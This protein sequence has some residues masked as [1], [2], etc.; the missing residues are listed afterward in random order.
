MS[1]I[2]FLAPDNTLLE[3]AQEA[4]KAHHSDIPVVKGLLSEGVI[5]ASS[6]SDTGTEII[7][8]RGGTASAIRNAGIPVAVVEIPIT[9]FDIVRCVEKAKR[10]GN[11]IGVVSFSS[12]ILGIECLNSI[13]GVDIGLYPI[14]EEAEA[15]PQLIKALKDG[16]QVVIG[17]YITGKI[18]QK[19]NCPFELIE[20]G[21]EGLIQ[22]AEEAKRIAYARAL[23]KE[24]SGLFRAVL[25]YAYEGIISVDSQ[26]CITFFNPIAQRITNINSTEA[27]GRKI[28]EVWPNMDLAKVL[29][30]GEDDL[31]QI[32]TTNNV[33]VLCNKVPIR[34][35]NNIVGAVITFQDVTH[36]QKMEAKVRSSMY[37]CGHVANLCYSDIIGTS[38][39]I[40]QTIAIAK[41]YSLTNSSI[42]VIGETGSGKEVF[43]Q[44]IHNYSRRKHGPFVA[45][46]CAALPTN[47]L[48]SE[49]FGYVGGAFTGANQKG[50]PGLLE[51]AHGGT[52]F[53]D[54]I[55]EM[56]YITQGKLLRVLQ[57]KKVMRLGSDRVIPVDIRVIAATNK[58]LKILVN[59]NKFRA[60][61]YY[62]LNV[63]QLKIPPL[64]NRKEDI[65]LLAQLFLKMHADSF[66]R[67]LK[68]S[69]SAIEA[70]TQY[71]WPGNIRELKNI[72]ERIA[73]VHKQDVVD[74]S[75]IN[76]L[77]EDVS[78]SDKVSASHKPNEIEEINKA[79]ALAKG[80]YVDA[81]R[82]L[83]IDRSTL[84]RKMKRL[85]LK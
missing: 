36:I 5:I 70:L 57:E 40:I 82:I 21:V 83:G 61:L 32:I 85:K 2:T 14:Q 17:G 35:N 16:A 51:I 68:L 24:K 42:L 74:A 80:K 44:S 65:P 76:L 77:L 18:A 62:R 47:I 46:N 53:L 6:L 50:K 67:P 75:T 15:E 43:S 27:I 26:R 10:F 37:A 4:Y 29:H 78:L 33:D 69:P 3:R 30:S 60:D 8:T 64:R 39:A 7:I 19:Y 11:T 23:E 54:E 56:D 58:D 20:S 22:A 38:E 13:L 84:W 34:V 79:L 28:S 31:G 66:K 1:L 12:M 41:D 55:A 63:L 9:G 25:D 48:E 59:E 49:L 71:A 81:A 73:A 45:V 52:I 72:M